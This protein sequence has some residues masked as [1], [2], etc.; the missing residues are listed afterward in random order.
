MAKCKFIVFLIIISFGILIPS[1]YMKGESSSDNIY[2]RSSE[3]LDY[4]EYV[5][6]HQNVGTDYQV[7]W[8]FLGQNAWV[9]IKVYAMTFHEF[10]KFQNLLN[11]DSHILSNGSYSKDSGIFIPP[12]H[13]D[14]YIVFHNVDSK[15]YSTIL[16]YDVE[17]VS[18]FS[19]I[20]EFLGYTFALIAIGGLIGW[21]ITVSNK[22]QK[23][24]N[25]F[26][27]KPHLIFLKNKKISN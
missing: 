10:Y 11:F 3:T 26:I 25:K 20:A 22:K 4:G 27:M 17:F 14:W 6:I 1:Q 8:E 21:Y 13:A 12:N 24:G 9:G 2:I 23:K 18:Y 16:I 19:L 7:I 15:W 5:Y